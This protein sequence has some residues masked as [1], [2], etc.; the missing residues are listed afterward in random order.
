MR[1]D[2]GKIP[3]S[4]LNAIR[5]VTGDFYD[6][7]PSIWVRTF[8]EGDPAS[9]PKITPAD[10]CVMR[11]L[12]KNSRRAPTANTWTLTKSIEEIAAEMEL[13]RKT[14]GKSVERL[15]RLGTIRTRRGWNRVEITVIH[16]E[17]DGEDWIIHG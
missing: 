1:M 8:W 16:L 7:P 12:Y 14:V 10:R 4:R 13:D 3:E 11:W 5:R 6:K 2:A 17:Q 9:V 15:E